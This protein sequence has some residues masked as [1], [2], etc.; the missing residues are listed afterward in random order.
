MD[1]SGLEPDNLRKALANLPIGELRYYPSITSTNTLAAEW[2]ESGAPD[3]SLVLADEQTAG[4]GRY[5]RKWFTPAGAALAFSIILRPGAA[6]S[7]DPL[8]AQKSANL[9]LRHT[10][11]GSL[12][13]CDALQNLYGL[14]AQIK[15][16][17]DVLLQSRKFCG[18]LAEGHWLGSQLQAVVLGIG[19]NISPTAVPPEDEVVYPATCIQAHT[20]TQVKRSV[21]LREILSQIIRWRA[22]LAQPEF[23]AA[24]QDQLAYQDTWVVVFQGSVPLEQNSITGKILG[25]DNLGNLV[26]KDQAGIQHTIQ[27]GELHLRPIQHKQD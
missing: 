4:R 10:A 25:L 20:E 3:L 17:N 26:I 22:R 19:A 1:A 16:P 18:I 2:V 13:V 15:W 21:L 7:A 24:W 9:V 27:Y 23:I 12:A 11:L 5:E 14:H 8:T 6:T